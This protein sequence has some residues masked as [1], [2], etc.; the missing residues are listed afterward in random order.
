MFRQSRIVTYRRILII[1]III[2]C[3][4]TFLEFSLTP[5][6]HN[7]RIIEHKSI[8]YN[9]SDPF[10]MTNLIDQYIDTNNSKERNN[11]WS[12]LVQSWLKSFRTYVKRTETLCS[13]PDDFLHQYLDEYTNQLLLDNTDIQKHLTGFGLYIDYN[14]KQI[15]SKTHRIFH[16]IFLSS[17]SYFELILLIMKVQ[18]ILFEL[19]INYFIGKNTLIGALRHHDIIP[20]DSIVEFNLPLDSKDKL[21]NNINK[22]FQLIIEKVNDSY[23]DKKQIGFIYKIFLEDKIW[24]QIQ[25]YF[26]QQN[27]THIYDNDKSIIK[28]GYL[29]KKHVFPLHLRPFGP[30]LLF[31]INNP[32]SI[33]SNEVLNTCETMSWN[34][35]LEK[36]TDMNHQ[37][38]IPCEQ[39]NKIYSFVQSR[40]SWR[41]GYC[42]ETL[43]T[44]RIPYKSLSYFRYT[45]QENMIN[46]KN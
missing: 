11:L 9:L 42:E 15:R 40:Y 1:C 30:I 19:N 43:K 6:V 22:K 25:I 23:I 7:D 20:W 27:S 28:I 8:V 4:I 12:L 3:L 2:C 46:K 21:I 18:F 17:C 45:C 37:G 31:S 29:D 32:Q 14:P 16:N 24:P 39:L 10:I 38:R 44:Q 35:Q 34:H 41:R 5:P 36:Q 26:Y 13:S 33:I